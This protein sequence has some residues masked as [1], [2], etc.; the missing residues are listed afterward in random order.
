MPEQTRANHTRFDAKFHFFVVPLFVGNF[1]WAVWRLVEAFHIYA[2]WAVVMS[3]ASLV[4]VFTIRLYSLKVQDRIIRLEE[5]LRIVPLL[6]AAVRTRWTEL[7]E[8]QLVALRFA[9]DA[10]VGALAERAINEKLAPKAIKEA[11]QVW[12]PDHFRV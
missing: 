1:I 5:R 11:I 2:V 10:E 8:P 3:A 6:P 9:S 4:M 12:R 7:S